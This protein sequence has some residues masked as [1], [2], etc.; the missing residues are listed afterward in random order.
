[1]LFRSKNQTNPTIATFASAGKVIFRV[2]A[3]AENKEQCINLIKPVT[4]ELI[5]RF[6]KE[7][8]Y[9]VDSGNVE[10]KVAELLLEKNLTIAV[11]ESL[12]GGLVSSRLISY[13]GISKSFLEGFVTYS[14]ESKI[15]RLNVKKDT[16]EKYGAVSQETAKEMAYGAALVSGAD[17]GLSTTGIAGPD[18]GSEE[19]PVGLVFVCVYY[20]G[21][22]EVKNIRASGTRDTI[23]ERTATNALDLVRSCIEK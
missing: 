9:L 2:T 7:N 16:I 10:D 15:R 21:K 17:I 13:P 19:K 22:Y 1:M 5:R 6:G 11:A 12:T 18:G 8:A 20:D 3:K 14:N 4:E 23:R